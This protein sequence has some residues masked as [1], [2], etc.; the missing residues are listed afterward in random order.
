MKIA[1]ATFDEGSGAKRVAEELTRQFRETH[2][3]I[4][5]D[6][7]ALRDRPASPELIAA[8]KKTDGDLLLTLSD[9]A[10][11]DSGMELVRA[12]PDHDTATALVVGVPHVRESAASEPHFLL[13]L[14]LLT[15]EKLAGAMDNFRIYP[16]TLILANSEKMAHEEYGKGFPLVAALIDASRSG[17]AL[18]PVEVDVGAYTRVDGEDHT[19]PRGWFLPKLAMALL[20]MPR[21]K[22]C[23]RNFHR[24]KFMELLLHP[25]S[26]LKY[27]LAENASPA[28]LAAAAAVGMFIGTL[29]ILGLHTITI[30][31]VSVM[32]RLNKM[33]S[34]NISH[35]CMP[36]FVPLACVWI[37]HFVI[38]G[39]PPDMDASA[40]IEE[41]KKPTSVLIDWIVGALVLAPIN[42]VV[43][44]TITFVV[45]SKIQS[46]R[47]KRSPDIEQPVG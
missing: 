40:L 31:Y 11:S 35:L 28:G 25:N 17:Y 16:V 2:E 21:K 37:G 39:T 46:L 22:L 44:A 9:D 41:L 32:L 20:P 6:T 47:K 34:V 15:G 27:L 43:F 18:V 7:P 36:P 29:P 4:P 24:E 23:P 42:A 45:T 5:L 1:V 33:M 10:P 26:F 13:P 12:M 38:T 30:I 14:Q 8:L 3:F 19:P